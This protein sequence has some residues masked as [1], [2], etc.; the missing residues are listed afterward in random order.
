MDIETT[1]GNIPVIH[2]SALERLNI[3][4]LLELVLFEADNYNIT[5]SKK[6]AGVGITLESKQEKTK[7]CSMIVREGSFSKGD[8]VISESGYGKIFAIYNDLNVQ[9]K[10]AGPGDSVELVSLQPN[11]LTI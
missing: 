6:R 2:I 10:T 5:G 11:I 3:D 9:V 7:R 4:L 1:G 8:V